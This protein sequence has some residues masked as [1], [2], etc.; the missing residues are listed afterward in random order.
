VLPAH[1]RQHARQRLYLHLRAL[2]RGDFGIIYFD[3]P[4]G[5]LVEALE[6]DTERLP[7]L[8]HAAQVPAGPPRCSGPVPHAGGTPGG[9]PAAPGAGCP[10]RGP[11]GPGDRPVV[12]VTL[13]ANGDVELHLVVDVVGLGLAQV[14]VDPRA[15]EHHPAGWRAVGEQPAQSGAPAPKQTPT[16]AGS[17]P[18]AHSPK[19]RPREDGVGTPGR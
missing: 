16:K 11:R 3:L 8:L 18:P 4:L 2:R 17:P 1:Q 6:N 14:P 5:H 10:C 7:H 19:Q 15:P 13:G 9:T 12:A